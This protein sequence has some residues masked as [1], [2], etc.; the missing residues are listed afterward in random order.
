MVYSKGYQ[1][2]DTAVSSIVAKV[3]GTTAICAQQVALDECPD[4]Q[5]LVLDTS[6]YVVP[7]QE[8]NAVFILTNSVETPGQTQAAGGWDE[9]SGAGTT[10]SQRVWACDSDTDC[11]RFASSRNGVLTGECGLNSRC[12]IFGWGPPEQTADD[13]ASS[14][15]GFHR[16]MPGVQDFTIYVKNQIFFPNFRARF[17]N[18]GLGNS[19]TEY[20]RSCLWNA[21]TDP[22]CPVFRVGDML[23]AAGIED[24]ESEIM[25]RG[26]VIT[27]GLTYDCDLDIDTGVEDSA[28]D[29]AA[30]NKNPKKNVCAP[31]VTFNRIDEAG[32][33]LASGY[34]FRFARY[35]VGG[36]EPVRTLTKAY[37]VRFVFVVSGRAGRFSI[38]PLLIAFGSGIGLLSL[39]TVAADFAATRLLAQRSLYVRHKYHSIRGELDGGGASALMNDDE[40]QPLLFARA[41]GA[42]GRAGGGGDGVIDGTVGGGRGGDSQV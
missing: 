17:D 6:D 20:L 38:V 2:H 30:V 23:R 41:G 10:G 11:P 35:D 8:N 9:D 4:D 28:N 32:D 15:P 18:T 22:Y 34:N 24:F 36:T 14:A 16:Q 27:M 7:A 40:K 26:G 37:G 33:P 3:K 21:T 39:A 25:V 5:I 19:T 13:S 1:E 29:V 42:R 31:S 12:R